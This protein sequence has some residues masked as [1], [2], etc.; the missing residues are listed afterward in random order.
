MR[1]LAYVSLFA[2]LG[3]A[4]L[5]NSCSHQEDIILPENKK[6]VMKKSIA[7]ENDVQEDSIIPLTR[8]RKK[9]SQPL[10]QPKVQ[11]PSPKLVSPPP[12]NRP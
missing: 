9:P 11:E 7:A 6:A 5:I 10:P 12:V 4:V 8:V 1:K 2:F 3:F